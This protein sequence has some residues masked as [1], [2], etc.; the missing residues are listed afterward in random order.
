VQFVEDFDDPGL[1]DLLSDNPEDQ[2]AVSALSNMSAAERWNAMQ[3]DTE[4]EVNGVT[5]DVTRQNLLQR[6]QGFL[7]IIEADQS[8][9]MLLDKRWQLREILQGFE[10]GQE[11]VLPQADAMLQ[12]Q[13]TAMLSQMQNPQP[14]GQAPGG[15]PAEGQPG[16]PGQ[17]A[18][19]NQHNSQQA[20]AAQARRPPQ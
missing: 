4:F 15:A 12:A 2:Q 7:Q 3:L 6:L 13:Q 11:A 8:L 14:Q 20:V 10:F 17:M 19:Q 1:M 18:G 5:R 9:A 16:V